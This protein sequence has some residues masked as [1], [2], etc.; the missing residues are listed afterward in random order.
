M[1]METRVLGVA[2][3]EGVLGRVVRSKVAQVESEVVQVLDRCQQRRA[4]KA[5]RPQH[6]LPDQL[7]ARTHTHTH[8]PNKASTNR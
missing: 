6:R 5:H 4:H 1:T 2:E 3:E 7:R 8:T